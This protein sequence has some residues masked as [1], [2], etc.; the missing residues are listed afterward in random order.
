MPPVFFLNI[1]L[2]LVDMA[3]AEQGAGLYP[4]WSILSKCF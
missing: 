1:S 2:G 4:S 3:F